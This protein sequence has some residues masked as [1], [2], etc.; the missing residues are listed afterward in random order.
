LAEQGLHA[1]GIAQ[2]RQGLAAHEATGAL[3]IRPYWLSL[4]AQAY[5]RSGQIEDGLRVLE[6]ALATTHDQHIWK[7]ELHRLLGEL[8]LVL[9]GGRSS[10]EAALVNTSILTGTGQPV[11]QA[12][13]CFRYA[14]EVARGQQSKS[15]EL[16]AGTS[17][18]RL[19][20]SHNRHPEGR[21]LLVPIYNSFT[22][23]FDTPDL[24][25]AKA[26]LDELA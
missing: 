6:E 21:D 7:A 22:E 11:A 3:L 16:R 24:K 15:L 10:I 19:W 12:E 9:P 23:G 8:L 1:E 25:E 20:K 2:I 13:Q 26:L 14:V 18:A 4:L 5:G 17:L